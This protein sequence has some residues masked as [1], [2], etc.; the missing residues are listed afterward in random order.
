[1][2]D[3]LRLRLRAVIPADASEVVRL[4]GDRDIASTTVNIPHPYEPAMADAWIAGNAEKFE[5][6]EAATFAITRRDEGKLIGAVSLRF[7]PG[8]RRAE[9]GYWVGR[10]YWGQGIGTEAAT[11]VVDW[12]FRDRDLNRIYAHHMT[13]NPASG[14]VMV[15]IG[16]QHEGTLR[17]HYAKW[18]VLEDV[19]LYAVLREEWIRGR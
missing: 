11:A 15:K 14:Q 3:T 10:P 17:Q 16:M 4:A 6:G 19:E 13:R 9:L 2:L 1:M 5:R 18:G 7:T 12:G 8:D